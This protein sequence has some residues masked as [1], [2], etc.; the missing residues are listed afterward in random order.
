MHAFA[1][2]FEPGRREST[3]SSWARFAFE[4]AEETVA[5]V[6]KLA[7]EEGGAAAPGERRE[8][9]PAGRATKDDARKTTTSPDRDPDADPARRKG[10][11]E[12]AL[13]APA[14]GREAAEGAVVE[15]G[16]GEGGSGEGG[17]S[18]S[19]SSSRL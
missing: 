15:G 16:G 3:A 7:A 11:S 19:S 17:V 1:L 2:P 12:A 8:A 9:A 5:R 6:E 14:G 4:P 10:T 13:N 18:G